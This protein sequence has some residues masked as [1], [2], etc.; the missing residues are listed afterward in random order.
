MRSAEEWRDVGDWPGCA[1]SDLGQVRTYER[2]SASGH[3]SGGAI[4]RPARRE[5]GRLQV[6]LKDGKRRRRVLV[7]ELV[8][9]AFGP[10]RPSG[11]APVHRNGRPWDC[12]EANL[13]WG[14]PAKPP[15]G[16][17]T[18]AEP[19]SL[20]HAYEDGMFGAMTLAGLRTARHR[21]EAFPEAVSA[22]GT[23]SLYERAA[24][25]AWWQSRNR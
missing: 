3:L 17:E 19:I 21:D 20:T 5:D 14:M 25:A 13:R 15:R 9:E 22:T 10:R 12:R 7:A 24:L 1:V 6:T 11:W 18:G 23:S 8:L 16:R 4:L 2:R